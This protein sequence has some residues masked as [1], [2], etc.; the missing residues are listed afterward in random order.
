ME[1]LTEK[2]SLASNVTDFFSPALMS[3]SFSAPLL[4]VKCSLNSIWPLVLSRP[5]VIE[6]QSAAKI[7][8]GKT[9][10]VDGVS[11][12][13]GIGTPGVSVGGV[14]AGVVVAGAVVGVV[15]GGVVV[16]A[17]VGGVVVGGVVSH[18]VSG[19]FAVASLASVTTVL[20]PWR[21]SRFQ[22][23]S[24]VSLTLSFE[25]GSEREPVSQVP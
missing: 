14:V 7:S 9:G 21:P 5:I 10:S 4:G 2:P 18:C 13:V 24:T 12:G 11:D 6:S 20:W 1:S 17:V 16:G 3:R 15:V 22:V 23:S 19:L 8:S 25:A